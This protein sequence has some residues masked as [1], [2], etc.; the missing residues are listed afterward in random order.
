MG[1][2]LLINRAVQIQLGWTLLPSLKSTTF[3]LGAQGNPFHWSPHSG[4]SVSL[5]FNQL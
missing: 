5:I 4:S 1:T 2:V 3:H